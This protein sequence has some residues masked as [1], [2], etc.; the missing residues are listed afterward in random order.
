MKP[1]RDPDQHRA[2]TDRRPGRAP[3]GADLRARSPA[4][5][6]TSP[7]PSRSRPTTR[8]FRRAEPDRRPAHRLRDSRGPRADG[9]PGGR[10]PARRARRPA[11][12]PSGACVRLTCDARSS[13]S[14]RTRRGCSSPRSLTGAVVEVLERR[15]VITRLGAGVDADGR[16]GDEAMERV[17]VVLDEYR[18]LIDRDGGADAVAVLTSAVR[19]AANGA[20]VRRGRRRA[21]GVR[22]AHPDRRRGGAAD[23]PRR[24]QRT[25]PGRPDADARDRHRRR[26]DRVRDRDR[27]AR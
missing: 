11:D 19:D 15:T 1:T 24:H 17:F 3:A 23:V 6:S 5:R 18:S 27:P 4:P 7:T 14:A 12:A 9:R 26:L 8:C 10:Q 25:R 13:T 21:L 2:R 22:A 16:L 20:R